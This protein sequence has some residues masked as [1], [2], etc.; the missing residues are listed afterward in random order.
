[1]SRTAAPSGAEPS[2]APPRATSFD[3]VAY[4]TLWL[5][6]LYGLSARQVVPG[7]GAICTPA[8][9]VVLPTMLIWAAGWILPQSGLDRGRHPIR[10]ALMVYFAYQVLSFAVANSRPLTE[11]E[12]NGSV[13]ALLTAAAMAGVGL[14]VA[15]GVR[16]EA[17]LTTLLHR[18]VGAV[19]F[20]SVFG[21]VQFYTRQP[22]QVLVPGLEWNRTPIG[23]G[24]RGEFGR[25]ASTTLHP[26]EFSVIT[27]SLL[28]LALHFALHARTIHQRRN[29]ALAS[30]LIALAVPLSVSRSG[31]VSLV[32]ALGILFAGWRGRRL[33][34]GLLTVIIAIPVLWATVPGIVGTFIGLFTD[35]EHD[36]SIQARI[37][38]GPRVMAV[39]RER[40]WLGLGNGT[41]SV[42]DYFL[43]DNEVYG[44]TLEMG[45]IGLALTFALLGLAVLIAL[46]IR[47]LPTADA[48]TRHLA[49]AIA[50]A[51][52]ALTISLFTFDAF[53]YRIQ[54]GTLFLLIGA[55]GA[56][57][58]MHD[59][60]HHI[61]QA[62]HRARQNRTQARTSAASLQP[63]NR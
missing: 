36:P 32:V 25:P 39:I 47:A 9:L 21:I 48:A 45:I 15:D 5:V 11:L 12:S 6:L 59:G 43:I 26:I 27:A 51:I 30:G 54:T 31:V 28:P 37:N 61:G 24:G 2:T 44:T 41:F 52:A 22:M 38:R 4:L 42:E 18:L 3:V 17:R 55:T 34:H 29:A 20:V 46:G 56:L 50:A 10:T 33:I 35:T 58:R 23:V 53:F 49:L 7:L 13:R 57:W 60:S 16:D 1:M 63:E 8:M 19:T 14:L 62:I 40:P